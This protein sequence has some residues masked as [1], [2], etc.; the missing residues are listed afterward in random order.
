M[1]KRDGVVV[2][3]RRIDG[4]GEYERTA[5]G[6]REKTQRE[7]GGRE[8]SLSLVEENSNELLIDGENGQSKRER[9]KGLELT[10]RKSWLGAESVWRAVVVR[11]RVRVDYQVSE[12]GCGWSGSW[13]LGPGSPPL[14][15]APT[16]KVR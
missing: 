9:M 10:R 4:G 15:L 8:R 12:Q 11:L 2:K 1:G 6:G 3:G 13:V 7:G 16:N 14:G 5:A